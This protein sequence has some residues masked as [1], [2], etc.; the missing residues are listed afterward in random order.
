MTPLDRSLLHGCCTNRICV[1]LA[2]PVSDALEMWVV[3]DHPL[4]HPDGFIARRWLVRAGKQP[5]PL[6]RFLKPFRQTIESVNQTLKGQLD[7]ERHGGRTPTGVW[8]RVLQRI[9]ALTT[10]IWHNET[11][12]QTGPARSLL[13]YDH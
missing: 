13:A 3:Y 1:A 8:A 2:G 4:D 6:Q 5:R 9:L 12:H 11:T 10:V 7:L